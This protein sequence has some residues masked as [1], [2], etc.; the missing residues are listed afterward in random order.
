MKN[1]DS[2]FNYEYSLGDDTREMKAEYP[3]FR[4]D[5]LQKRFEESFHGLLEY[6]YVK[7]KDDFDFKIDVHKLFQ[8]LMLPDVDKILK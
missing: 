7:K 5:A 1:T 2:K 8:N 6:L 3:K 4:H